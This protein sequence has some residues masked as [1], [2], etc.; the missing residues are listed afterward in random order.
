ME[1]KRISSIA[2]LI[3]AFITVLAIPHP[4]GLSFKAWAYP[5]VFI[6]DIVALIL[7]VYPWCLRIF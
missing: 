6:G 7:V 1:S 4:S 3:I 2:A 5:A